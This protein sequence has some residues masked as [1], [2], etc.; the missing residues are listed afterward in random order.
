[1]HNR[2]EKTEEITVIERIAVTSDVVVQC[3]AN[4]AAQLGPGF[5][6]NGTERMDYVVGLRSK[7]QK[8]LD[9]NR[10]IKGTDSA[11]F[12]VSAATTG[13]IGYSNATMDQAFELIAANH[14]LGYVEIVCK[15]R[16]SNALVSAYG[17]KLSAA[18]N[19]TVIPN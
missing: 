6:P 14:P 15:M 12:N 5:T 17:S 16:V 7:T 2:V 9:Y 4:F 18:I 1:V 8:E 19:I 10:S 11:G 3:R 13:A